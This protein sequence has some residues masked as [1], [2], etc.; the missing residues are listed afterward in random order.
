MQG[1]LQGRV[2]LYTALISV[3]C[4]AQNESESAF[5]AREF[6]SE[7]DL[8]LVH[9]LEDLPPDVYRNLVWNR[10]GMAEWGQEWNSSDAIDINGQ[11]TAQHVYSGISDNFAASLYQASGARGIHTRLVLF[12]RRSGGSC[13]C[14]L[15]SDIPSVFKY[16][17][18]R[19]RSDGSTDLECVYRPYRQEWE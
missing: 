17:R 12:D 13:E 14:L 1:E 3:C 11:F 18:A 2:F 7:A 8:E 19:F 10:D 5:L 9:R 4:H 6:F 15:E 16:V